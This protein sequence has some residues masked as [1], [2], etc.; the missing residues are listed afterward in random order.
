MKIVQNVSMLVT[1]ILLVASCQTGTGTK[2]I[3]SKQETRTKIMTQIASDTSLSNEMMA[4]MMTSHNGM[5]MMQH[6]E[7]MMQMMKNDPTMMQGVM[8]GMMDM[9]KNDSTMMAGMCKTMM[10]NPQMMDMMGKMK[11]MD[12]TN[13]ADHTLHQ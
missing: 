13:K 11:G 1:L 3:L 4:T 12:T 10:A 8:T 6:H 5:G 7:A 9:C 2:D